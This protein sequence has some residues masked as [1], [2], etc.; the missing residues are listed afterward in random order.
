MTDQ[1][2]H[3]LDGKL[4]PEAALIHVPGEICALVSIAISLKRIADIMQHNIV[5]VSAET[6]EDIQAALD[7]LAGSYG[8]NQ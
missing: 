2:P 5:T 8:V 6:E 4:E 1:E 7:R 3:P